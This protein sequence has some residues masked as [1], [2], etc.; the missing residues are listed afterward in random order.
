MRWQEVPSRDEVEE[1]MR[2]SE[3]QYP[4]SIMERI[5]DWIAERL[6]R[7]LGGVDIPGE[8]GSAFGGG[9]GSLVGWLL[10]F[11]ALVAL[12]AVVVVVVRNRVRRQP[13]QEEPVSDTELEHRRRARAWA[14]D[15]DRFE[16]RGE[17]KLAMRARLRELVRTLTDRHQVVDLAG[18]TT[19][20]LRADL[21]VTTPPASDDFD[22]ACLLFE[23]PWYADV[24]TGESENRRFKEAAARVL[25][26][27]VEVRVGEVPTAALALLHGEPADVSTST[28][29]GVGAG[30]VG[31]VEVI[32]APDRPGGR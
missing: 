18:R 26:A 27:P 9:V 17:W 1:V 14:G 7:I 32:E 29:S 20:E 11:I 8:P 24:P 12:V 25:A 15:A 13:D 30:A 16:S 31:S 6:E 10:V 3:F 4:R 22:T 19:G 2:R 28:T 21:A 5:G 23:L